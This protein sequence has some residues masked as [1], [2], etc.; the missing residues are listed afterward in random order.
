MGKSDKP[1]DVENGTWKWCSYH[2]SNGHSNDNCYQQQQSVK[3]CARITGAEAI[4]M[5]R[6]ITREMVSVTLLLTVKVVV[7]VVVV[8]DSNIQRIVLATE[9]TNYG[10]TTSQP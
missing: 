3:N 6:A 8:D 2:H 4:P 1:S 5:T 9:K 7:V 10:D